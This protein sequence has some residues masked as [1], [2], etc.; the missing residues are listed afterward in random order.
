MKADL[1]TGDVLDVSVCGQLQ[2]ALSLLGRNHEARDRQ[3]LQQIVLHLNKAMTQSLLTTSA[4]HAAIRLST[5]F[6][7]KMSRQSTLGLL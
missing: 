4:A 1:E 2:R 3:Q 5:A 6:P 7:L